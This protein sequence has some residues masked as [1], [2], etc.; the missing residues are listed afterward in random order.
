VIPSYE[1]LHE[2]LVS[3]ERFRARLRNHFLVVA[4]L[5][6]FSIGLGM[7]GFHLLAR[8]TWV[9]A[10]LNTAMLLGGMG[11]TGPELPDAPAKL[12][13]GVYALYAGLFFIVAATIL[14]APVLHRIM[15]R[16]HLER[17]K[18]DQR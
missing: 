5:L 6:V 11:P 18:S 1:R 4:G 17:G 12:F 10:F 3:T 7:I 16:F 8:Y 15:H 2:A 14:F 9:D 13:A